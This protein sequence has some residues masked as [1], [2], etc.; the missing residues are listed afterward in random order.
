ME[1]E[2]NALL[3]DLVVEYHKLQS[4]H[5]YLKGSH[6]FDYHAKLESFYDEIAEA[7]DA[8]AE[9]MLQQKLRPESTLKGFLAKTGIHEA[10]NEEVASEE[11]YTRV[12]SDFEYLLKEVIAVKEAAEEKKNYLVSTL[13]DD[14]IASFSKNIWMLRQALK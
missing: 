11:A 8:V 3:S 4:F 9:A 6:F 13:M 7:V 14:Y 1:K 12:L 2:L 5:W 10:E